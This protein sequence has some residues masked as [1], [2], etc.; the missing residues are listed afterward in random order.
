MEWRQCKT[1]AIRCIF[2][3]S[4]TVFTTVIA[5]S[6]LYVRTDRT[7]MSEIC[8]LLSFSPDHNHFLPCSIW[9][10]GQ[11]CGLPVVWHL[12]LE[13]LRKGPSLKW[14]KKKRRTQMGPYFG[15]PF[16]R[17][18]QFLFKKWNHLARV[19]L[20]KSVTCDDVTGI[21]FNLDV[22]KVSVIAIEE[23]LVIKR[24]S[25][26]DS[27]ESSVSSSIREENQSNHTSNH[28]CFAP[29]PPRWI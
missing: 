7:R 29:L 25:D 2:V 3:V 14:I 13:L 11:R 26:C 8:S 21:D 23:I 27:C 17:N 12:I 9:G 6:A 16:W 5:R 15:P 28:M 19:H 4:L 22:Q 1:E 20:W 24:L 18:F 10:W